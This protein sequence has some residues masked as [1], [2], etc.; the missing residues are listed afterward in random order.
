LQARGHDA[1]TVGGTPA[2][3]AGA[4]IAGGRAVR[5]AAAPGGLDR[6]PDRRLDAEPLESDPADL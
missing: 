1:R 5:A 3:A 2:R 4:G 6:I